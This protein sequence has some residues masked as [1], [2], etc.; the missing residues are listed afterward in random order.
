MG[1]DVVRQEDFVME[2]DEYLANRQIT[3]KKLTLSCQ[4]NYDFWEDYIHFTKT[5]G[6]V[7]KK[8]LKLRPK[9]L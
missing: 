6:N 7:I 9:S 5:T 2:I 1:K 4:P 8:Q 3:T